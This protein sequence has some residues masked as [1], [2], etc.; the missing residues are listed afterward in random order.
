MSISGR[1]SKMSQGRLDNAIVKHAV[2]EW[3]AVTSRNGKDNVN[4]HVEFEDTDGQTYKQDFFLSSQQYVGV[5]DGKLITVSEDREFS[6]GADTQ[7]GKYLASLD[8]A[9]FSAKKLDNIGDA[10]EA[11]V[12]QWVRVKQEPT[13]RLKDDGTP[14]TN[15]VVAAL[16]DEDEATG[17]KGKAK[18]KS[19]GTKKEAKSTKGKA[20]KS[21]KEE[22]PEEEEEEESEDE[23]TEEEDEDDEDT[24]DE[25][26]ESEDDELDP[27]T[28]AAR[29][30]MSVILSDLSGSVKNF[31]PGAAGGGISIKQAYVASFTK[32]T[33]KKKKGPISN[34]INDA[35]F[36]KA[37]A[38]AGLYRFDAK[39]GVIAPNKKGRR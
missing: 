29:E 12:D 16:V 8:E 33:D 26:E 9:G 3:Q 27:L 21:V 38:A 34:L 20:G 36:H 14:F 6:I 30:T 1:K 4:L 23:D 32:A 5:E 11:L 19:A 18:G 24:E 17:G 13:S 15:L 10:P 28:E 35:E 37:A 22:E 25:D 31:D 39:K 7:A 2:V